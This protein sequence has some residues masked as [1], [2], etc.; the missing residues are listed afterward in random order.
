MWT[1]TDVSSVEIYIGSVITHGSDRAL[2][3]HVVGLLTERNLPAVVFANIDVSE[4]QIDLVVAVERTALVLEGKAL[5][6]PVRGGP[7][8]QWQVRVASGAWKN[9]KNHYRQAVDASYAVRDA[10]RERCTEDVPYPVAALVFT[11]GQPPGSSIDA[12]EFKAAIVDLAGIAPLLEQ[13]RSGSWSLSRWRDFAEHHRLTRVHDLRTAF[14]P[15]LHEAEQ[16]IAIYE[17][18]VRRAYQP[19]AHGLVSFE[20]REDKVVCTADEIIARGASGA[21]LLLRGPSGCAKT[22]MAHRIAV[23]CIAQG[24]VPMVIPAKNFDGRLRDL[25]HREAVL[26]EAP[27]AESLLASC[28]QLDRAITVIV[29]GYNECPAPRRAEL[30]RYVAV[31]ARRYQASVVVT[32]QI[33]LERADLLSL[34]AVTVPEPTRDTKHAIAANAANGVAPDIALE[35]L[36]NSVSTGLEARLVGEVGQSIG[37][38]VSRYAI[39][40]R[41]VRMRLGPEASEGISALARMAGLL[42]DRISFSL[43]LRDRDRFAEQEGIS[44]RL[45]ERLRQTNLLIDRGDRSS[46]GHELFL[47]AFVAES[48]V[49]RAQGDPQKILDALH[50]SQHAERRSLIVGAIDDDAL[51][52]RVLAETTDSPVISACASGQCGPMARAWVERRCH[53]II[54]R[55]HQEASQ[56]AF[57]LDEEGHMGVTTDPAA[58]LEWSQPDRAVLAAIPALVADGKFLDEIL[59]IAKAIDQRLA[60]EHARLREEAQNRKIALRSGLFSA[61]YVWPGQP[62]PAFTAICS[63]LHSGM[64]RHAFDPQVHERLAD[65]ELTHGQVYVLLMLLRSAATDGPSVAPLLAKIIGRLWN[66]AAYHLRIDLMYAAQCAAWRVSE[67]DRHNLADA[68]QALPQAS[69][70]F[71]S[72][73]IIDALKALGALNDSETE[74]TETV[75]TQIR[76]ALADRTNPDMR[77]LAYTVWYG[78]F[79]HPFDGAYC[80][81]VSELADEEKKTLLTMAAQGATQD[82]PF[83]SILLVELATHNEP[84]SGSLIARWTA[85]PP[86]RCAMRQDAIGDFVTAHIALG[87]LGCVLP[88]VEG[89]YA[90]HAADALCACGEI[91][92]WMNRVDIPKSQRRAGCASALTVLSRHENGVA[93]SIIGETFHCLVSDEGLSRLP[94][95]EPVRTCIGSCFPI[96]IAEVF[97]ECL[98]NPT[99]QTGYFEWLNQQQTFDLAIQALGAWGDTTDIPVLRVWSITRQYGPSAL[100]AIRSLEEKQGIPVAPSE[101]PMRFAYRS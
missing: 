40:D 41:Y 25:V 75:R 47:N 100:E 31:M 10:M 69:H 54:V 43:T 89:R 88:E 92:Y 29:D 84:A 50:S 32:T 86:T 48:I 55:V 13:A 26:L 78:Q 17:T 72:G 52:L 38:G 12:R 20:C 96:E 36:L 70:P 56:L 19:L 34:A 77:A 63:P 44:A 14:D 3:E 30:T 39:F 61:C 68:I 58:L 1:G 62:A 5:T 74:Y 82:S 24:R 101:T 15:H 18:A 23:E 93:G 80:T 91:L 7:T 37:P 97:R 11:R 99:H 2:L 87:R 46:F 33:A 83:A 8:G 22:M 98:N 85:L 53:E 66:S 16:L 28:R 94:G 45:L 65:P 27:S 81:A 95:G 42:S 79:D 4:R 49:R 9:I 59:R 21:D 90:S 67:D 60:K 35:P 73:S 6:S 64:V 71:V 57:I 51:C 76:S